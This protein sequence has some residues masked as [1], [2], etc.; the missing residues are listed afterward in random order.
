MLN[1]VKMFSVCGTHGVRSSQVDA[2]ASSPCTK[3]EYKDIRTVDGRK[4]KARF[5]LT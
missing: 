1:V 4:Q 5:Y 3:Q 2:K